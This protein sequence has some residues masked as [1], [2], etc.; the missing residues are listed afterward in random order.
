MKMAKIKIKESDYIA[1]RNIMKINDV[2]AT[3]AFRASSR[4]G[5]QM[6]RPN[7]ISESAPELF[8]K[9]RFVDGDYD[10]GGA[11][12]GGGT[13]IMTLWCGFSRCLGTMIFVRAESRELAKL[14]I[15]TIYGD[16]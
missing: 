11:Y 2:L 10:A 3:P 14:E 15:H 7:R 5:A 1:L 8:Q 16:M 12:W 4:Y 9:V 13:G 6:G